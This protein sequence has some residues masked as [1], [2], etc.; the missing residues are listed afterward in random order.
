MRA[1]LSPG[2]DF[3]DLARE[4]LGRGS[5]LR[6]RA[7]GWSMYPTL[8]DGDILTIVPTNAEE[9]QVGDIVLC[10]AAGPRPMVHR[11]VRK[12]GGQ[13]I[14]R[15]DRLPHDDA[16]VAAADLLG[17]V[18]QAERGD[19][20]IHLTHRRA[21]WMGKLVARW[22]LLTGKLWPWLARAKGR[23]FSGTNRARH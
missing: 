3:C 7:E 6:Y 1:I 5:A 17:R 4:I 20:V 16:P 14:T 23:L 10:Q 12:A 21:I 13:V 9:A 11:L 19:K 8:R 18:I 22:P 15:G 2:P